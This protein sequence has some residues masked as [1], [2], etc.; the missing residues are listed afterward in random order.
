MTILA[1]SRIGCT[2]NVSKSATNYIDAIARYGK[3]VSIDAIDG[4]PAGGSKSCSDVPAV[5]EQSQKENFVFECSSSES[6]ST[7]GAFPLLDTKKLLS[8]V[9][10]EMIKNPSEAIAENNKFISRRLDRL[11][12][13]A[14]ERPGCFQY[15][16]PDLLTQQ[17]ATILLAQLQ[18]K[19]KD[20]ITGSMHFPKHKAIL[21]QFNSRETVNFLLYYGEKTSFEKMPKMTLDIDDGFQIREEASA[22]ENSICDE[23][24]QHFK[25]WVASK[26]DGELIPSRNSGF[27]C[28]RDAASFEPGKN[29]YSFWQMPSRNT[30][31]ASA[32]VAVA[33]AVTAY[34][35]YRNTMR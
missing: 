33:L 23:L 20:R 10:Q 4:I 1:K 30:V 15:N 9:P 12:G 7:F 13:L 5:I 16:N 2:Y 31:L 29:I 35:T 21:F 19:Y 11:D 6:D 14:Y 22:D 27:Q 25:R 32:G 24:N 8:D 34:A 26:Y 17:E 18:D 28:Y 3:K